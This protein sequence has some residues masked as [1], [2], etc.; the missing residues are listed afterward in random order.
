MQSCEPSQ[1]RH[2]RKVWLHAG[3]H[4]LSQIQREV[5]GQKFSLRL[6][7]CCIR[8]ILEG[9]SN[10]HC[11]TFRI[12]RG[13][14]PCSGFRWTLS[15]EIKYAWWLACFKCG[16]K[17]WTQSRPSQIQY[18][19]VQGQHNSGPCRSNDEHQ[20]AAT[21]RYLMD[22]HEC[23][24]LC[25]LESN[26]NYISFAKGVACRRFQSCDSFDPSTADNY[27]TFVKVTN[28]LHF[29]DLEVLPDG[30]R[31][32]IHHRE[33]GRGSI[34]ER[35]DLVRITG[36]QDLLPCTVEVTS[37]IVSSTKPRW[38]RCAG[39]AYESNDP[40]QVPFWSS[41]FQ[42]SDAAESKCLCKGIM[43]Y[44]AKNGFM[45]SQSTSVRLVN[46]HSNC[47]MWNLGGVIN[48]TLIWVLLLHGK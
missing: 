38:R 20:E 16:R 42:R 21:Q 14:F 8:N 18:L 24:S 27:T 4:A 35:D 11:T 15:E 45:S 29:T 44:A 5:R 41:S 30:R 36:S 43:G 22:L 40:I 6:S 13:I 9:V 7:E 46:G 2:A 12:W 33:S 34:V 1:L 3:K 32:R 26:C 25:N 48:S 47:D 37:I 19:Q 23:K 10:C 28:E 17:E 31:A 39:D